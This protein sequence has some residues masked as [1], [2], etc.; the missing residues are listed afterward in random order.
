MAATYTTAPLGVMVSATHTF[1]RVEVFHSFFLKPRCVSRSS[2]VGS[3]ALVRTF[4]SKVVLSAGFLCV[5]GGV[6]LQPLVT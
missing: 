5:G 6:A 1:S 3:V 4:S 2:A